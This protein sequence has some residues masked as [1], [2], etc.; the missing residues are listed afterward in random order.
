MALTHPLDAPAAFNS[1]RFPAGITILYKKLKRQGVCFAL[2]P[3]PP[4]F[5][6]CSQAFKDSRTP[7]P[8]LHCHQTMDEFHYKMQRQQQLLLCKA[9]AASLAARARVPTHG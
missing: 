5:F 1:R 3:V 2:V 7:V 8:V 6:S 9:N 4:Y